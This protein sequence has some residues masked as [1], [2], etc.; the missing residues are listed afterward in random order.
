MKILV[1]EDDTTSRLLFSATLKKLGHTVMAVEDGQRALSV[2]QT[3]DYP[4][5]ISDWM[6]PDIEGLQL[7][8]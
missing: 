5:L 4:L 8:K 2:W 1:A 6:M 7:C 3:G